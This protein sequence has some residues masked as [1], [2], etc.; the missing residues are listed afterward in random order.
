MLGPY[1]FC[2]GV[3]ATID[4]TVGTRHFVTMAKLT[5]KEEKFAQAVGV[6][7]LSQ[8]DAYRSAYSVENMVEKSIHVAACK[9]AARANVKQ[10]IMELTKTR[11]DAVVNTKTFDVVKLFE[12]Y[13]AIA[14][15]DPNELIAQK[16]GACRHCWGDGGGYQW[17]EREYLEALAA[18]ERQPVDKAG[19]P[20]AMPDPAGGFGY[21][22]TA[23]PNPECVE[24]EGEGL[25]RVVPMDTTK[26]SP[27]AKLLYRG[28]QQTKEGVK[29]MFANQD[30]AL[31][32]IGR[33]L[34][35]FDDKLRVDL[36]GKVA[37]LKLTTNDPK[38]AAEA[39]AKMVDGRA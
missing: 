26:L 15:V 29:V 4:G 25:H 3:R 22:F 23:A 8:S 27:G 34:G 31:E 17:K 36:A 30:K 7:G 13:I 16:V 18:W 9:V 12:T 2:M 21:R 35:A 28:V 1:R 11:V 39:Y 38:E 19:Q 6:K 10:R 33:I 5:E 37:S 20:V 32:Q 14:F 24:C